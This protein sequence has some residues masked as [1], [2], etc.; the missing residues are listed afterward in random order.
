M[1]GER[2]RDHIDV[3]CEGPRCRMKFRLAARIGDP[4]HEPGN[5]V[6]V[7]CPGCEGVLAVEIPTSIPVP[8]L[9]GA[10]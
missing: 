6:N 9:R 8:F 3:T 10:W 7:I 5:T 1:W 2:K 4:G